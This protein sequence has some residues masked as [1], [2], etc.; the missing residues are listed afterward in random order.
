MARKKKK[1]RDQ[2]PA[3]G[4][5]AGGAPL[6]GPGG[7]PEDGATGDD[8]DDEG[9]EEE[10]EATPAGGLPAPPAAAE[11]A[12]PAAAAP[13]TADAAAA[14]GSLLPPSP[15]PVGGAVTEP[16][17]DAPAKKPAEKEEGNALTSWLDGL[18][19]EFSHPVAATLLLVVLAVA[20]YAN[21]YW[22]PWLFDDAPVIT[23]NRLLWQWDTWSDLFWSLPTRGLTN[24]TFL[25]NFQ[26]AGT[27]AVQPYG[28]TWTYHVV[29]V[30]LHAA[31]GLLL[32]LLVRDLLR[33]RSG[34][35]PPGAP[36]F[37]A[38]VGAA[39]WVVHPANTMAVAYIAQRYALMAALAFLGTL[40]LYVRARLRM[41]ARRAEGKPLELED[42]LL[43][44]GAWLVSATCYVTKEN[45]AV[46][47]L[48]ALAIELLFFRGRALWAVGPFWLLVLLGAGLRLTQVDLDHFFPASSPTA[49]NRW[50]YF[51]TQIVVQLRYLHLFFMP[52]DLCVEQNFPV[53]W[54][55][56]ALDCA[57]AL[58]GHGLI[59]TL[60][61]LLFLRGHR[62]LPLAIV[63]YYATNIVESSFI[64]ILD[65]MVDHRMYL[66][67]AL[68][69]PALAGAVARAWPAASAALGGRDLLVRRALTAAAVLLLF[70]ES[71]GT[72]RRVSVWSSSTGIWEDTIA[73]RPDC[74]RA[75]SSL[76]M[77]HLYVGEWV[78]AVGPIEAALLLG[79]YH[80]EGWNNLG[81]AYLELEQW[82]PA[83]QAL[84]RGIEVHEV[85]P[86]PSI[87]L[88]HNNLG[89]VYFNVA[90]RENDL[91]TK[92]GWLKKAEKCLQ[93][94][95]RLDVMYE[96]AWINL[97]NAEAQMMAMTQGD[98]RRQHASL[99]LEA[100]KNAEAVATRRGGALSVQT[101]R[102]LTNA[103]VELGQ[104]QDGW[105][106]I[107]Q[108]AAR[109]GAD[110]PTLVEDAALIALRWREEAAKGGGGAIGPS[111]APALPVEVVAA[112]QEAAKLLDQLLARE[113]S[114]GQAWLRRGQ[115]ADA[116]GD[117]AGAKQAYGAAL[118][119]ATPG[120]PEAM[121]IEQ[122]LKQL[123][124]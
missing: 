13:A 58:V 10:A 7:V 4:Q 9:E 57:V 109:F 95:V 77:E 5:P 23:R 28:S 34:E 98:Y 8:G 68:L 60:G 118:K 44:A 50:D 69:A 29:S 21:A 86:S 106:T 116:L 93:D 47:P 1:K 30:L 111:A 87:P 15:E 24:L 80:V 81:K 52:H 91:Q 84:Q 67:T 83:A 11:P 75:Y 82:E 3:G 53:L 54:Q 18:R 110:S 51:T 72:L 65:P 12:A 94:A 2:R 97:V 104:A 41:E 42:A 31:N 48:A 123:G 85:A 45:A 108:L 96:V 120:T 16:P 38:L 99:I 33:V 70:A 117:A 32:Y 101:Y 36:R 113:P 121:F 55:G 25:L 119:L 122:R 20:A 92:Y 62:L 78:A 73:K 66:P 76:G 90:L 89:L 124:G 112:A 61:T 64:P 105:R 100:V 27:S 14:A 35:V 71:V 6:P 17:A 49:T 56:K 115:L 102:T 37:V 39:A 19:E 79:P 114:R 46:V 22:V 103:Y 107:Q 26:V 59:W 74:A 88:C 63:W 43:L 40:V